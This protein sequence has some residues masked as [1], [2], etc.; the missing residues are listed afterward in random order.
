[1]SEKSLKSLKHRGV[2]DMGDDPL[3][4]CDDN[5]HITYCHLIYSYY[6]IIQKSTHLNVLLIYIDIYI[7][8]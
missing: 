1:M 7:Y 8:I 5:S 6:T 3:C 2:A 4:V